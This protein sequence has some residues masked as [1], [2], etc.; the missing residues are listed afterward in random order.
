MCYVYRTV[1]PD[2][3]C[4]SRDGVLKVGSFLFLEYCMLYAYYRNTY[5]RTCSELLFGLR[6]VFCL[7]YYLFVAVDIRKGV[8][9]N[10]PC[11]DLNM[12]HAIAIH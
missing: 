2:G 4:A 5:T 8:C 1:R 12:N 9:W 10:T 6:H 11:S 3:G 7:Q